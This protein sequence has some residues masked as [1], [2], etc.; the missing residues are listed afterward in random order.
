MNWIENSRDSI[1]TLNEKLVW[2]LHKGI[3]QRFI[4]SWW[5]NDSKKLKWLYINYVTPRGREG[6]LP[7]NRGIVEGSKGPNIIKIG[8]AQKLIFKIKNT[9]KRCLLRCFNY[10]SSAT[11]YITIA[12]NLLFLDESQIDQRL[13]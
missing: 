2:T 9:R 10:P 12:Y 5:G 7:R 8:D 3:W 11:F 1:C 13:S 4:V 6:G